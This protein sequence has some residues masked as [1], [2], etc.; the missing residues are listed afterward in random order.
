[1]LLSACDQSSPPPPGAGGTTG[2][3][4]AGG[5]GSGADKANQLASRGNSNRLDQLAD[6]PKSLMG[7]SARTAKNVADQIGNSQAQASNAADELSGEV[8][9]FEVAGLLWQIPESWE[10]KPTSGDMRAGEFHV[11]G[12]NG[13][14]AVVAFFHFPGTG[15]SAT[16]NL[17]RWKAQFR[18][19]DTGGEPDY[20]THAPRKV[21][22][23]T[24]HVISIVGTFKEGMP[25]QSTTDRPG[26][27]MRGAVVEGGPKGS[28]FI[29]MTGPFDVVNSTRDQWYQM[30]DG[31]TRKER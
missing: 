16:A 3:S 18:N 24:V 22:G 20:K 29:K 10:Q 30:I 12:D 8:G 5:S 23:C 26:Y 17:D 21:A 31:M 6:E 19:P 14:T 25:G 15:G 2:T 1:M 4:T 7:R 13:E 28:V 27:A 11:K 9:G